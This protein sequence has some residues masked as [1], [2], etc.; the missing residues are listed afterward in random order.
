MKKFIL[1]LFVWLIWLI[2]FWSCFDYIVSWTTWFTFSQ[3]QNYRIVLWNSTDYKYY[4][5]DYWLWC[6]QTTDFTDTISVYTSSW[7]FISWL[8]PSLCIVWWWNGVYLYENAENTERNFYMRYI[9]IP[10]ERFGGCPSCPSTWDILSWYILE[11]D[12]T[13]NYCEVEF[14]LITPENCPSY[15]SWEWTWEIMWSSFYVNDEQ[16]LGG[17]NIYLTIP[18]YLKWDY[19]YVDQDLEIDVENEGDEEYIQGIIDINSYRPTSEDFTDIFVSG[20]TLVMPYIVIILF[21]VFV[22]KLI[23]RIF[24]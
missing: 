2:G 10:F 21:I 14:G 6:N 13:Q 7:E 17:A 9:N 19:T 23:K 18:D 11:S 4:F 1:S 15:W 12:I 8:T 3:N 16:I 20:L 5:S 22:W 24:K